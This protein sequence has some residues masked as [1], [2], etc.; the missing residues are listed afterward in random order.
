MQTESNFKFWNTEDTEPELSEREKA[1][2]DAFVA[3]YVIDY[4]AVTAAIRLGFKSSIAATYAA[5]FM[6]EPY[7]QRKIVEHERGATGDIPTVI[8]SSLLR[9]ATYKGAGSSHSARVSAL[10]QLSKIEGMDKSGGAQ[11]GAN[12]LVLNLSRDDIRKLDDD[13]LERMASI[14]AKI[15]IMVGT[16][17]ESA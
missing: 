5:R 12:G 16:A 13:D 17:P 3:Q 14:L 6:E 15:N 1:L 7:V 10:T 4:D 9:E 11:G 8:K 2:R